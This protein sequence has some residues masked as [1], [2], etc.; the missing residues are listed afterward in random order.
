VS[1]PIHSSGWTGPIES[2]TAFQRGEF[3]H[4][5]GEPDFTSDYQRLLQARRPRGP[6]TPVTPEVRGVMRL[7]A[8]LFLGTP[9]MLLCAWFFL[10]AIIGDAF[11]NDNRIWLIAWGLAA[12]ATGLTQ[13][14]SRSAFAAFLRKGFLALALAATAAFTAAYVRLGFT[15]HA[16]ASITAAERTYELYHNCGR[17]CGYYVHQ[18]ADGTTI[19][20]TWV[21][22]AVPYGSTCT[23]AQRL[24]GAYGFSWTRVLDRS[25]PSEHELIWPIRREDCFSDKPLST[26]KG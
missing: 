1:D 22:D 8:L 10:H 14:I 5:P 3:T 26:L 23:L 13:M 20:G 16:H 4:R 9:V 21:G 6:V 7:A 2:Q 19:E 12:M 17:N 24:D 15:A 25:P 18:R 11:V